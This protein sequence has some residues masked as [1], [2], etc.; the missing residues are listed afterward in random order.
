MESTLRFRRSRWLLMLAFLLAPLLLG[1][2]AAPAQATGFVA[3]H[4]VRQIGSSGHATLY[5]WGMSHEPDGTL[6]VSDYNNYNMK[7]YSPTGTLL[8]TFGSRGTA[9]NQVSQPYTTAVDPIDGSIY[10]ANPLGQNVLKYDSQGNYLSTIVVQAPDLVLA[11]YG[12]NYVYDAYINTDAQGHLWV[13]SSHNI[14]SPLIPPW[15]ARV[16]E[17]DRSGNLMLEF[18]VN[19]T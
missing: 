2:R 6:V 12:I 8:K 10:V 15:P 18:G 16:L 17:Y 9:I 7:L 3:P 1:I 11:Q 4:W 13:V 14:D 19:G 5:A